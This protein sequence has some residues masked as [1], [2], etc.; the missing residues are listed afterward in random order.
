M[1]SRMTLAEL[2]NLT[3]DEPLMLLIVRTTVSPTSKLVTV[4]C[5][6][7]AIV[8][9]NAPALTASQPAEAQAPIDPIAERAA[10]AVSEASKRLKSEC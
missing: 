2:Y 1:N 6:E 8:N 10:M 7:A 3:A 4:G 5:D 9:V